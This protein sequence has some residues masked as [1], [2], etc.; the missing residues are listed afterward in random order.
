MPGEGFGLLLLLTVHVNQCQMF[1]Y[2]AKGSGNPE[3][4]DWFGFVFE[5]LVLVRK[6]GNHQDPPNPRGMLQ[7]IGA[8]LW[9]CLEADPTPAAPSSLGR[10]AGSRAHNSGLGS[11]LP[12]GLQALRTSS[13]GSHCPSYQQKDVLPRANPFAEM[14]YGFILSLSF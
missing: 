3:R 11:G 5:P 12:H 4:L 8:S 7:G 14:S 13:P 10:V 9:Q 2:R 6:M 1:C